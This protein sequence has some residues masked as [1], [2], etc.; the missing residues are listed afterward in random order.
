[1]AASDQIW[2]LV[3]GLPEPARS[4]R[5]LL[6]LQAYIDDSKSF[7]ERAT[8]VL[9]GYI[10]PASCWA[11]FSDAWAKELAEPPQLAYFKYW[12]AMRR[13]P[14]GQFRHWSAKAR[15]ERLARFRAVVEQFV[16][17][18]FAVAFRVA[19][20]K[21]A[22]GR[23][24][25][26]FENPYY[27]AKAQ[28][29]FYLA[30]NLEALGLERQPIDFIFDMQVMEKARVMQAWEDMLNSGVTPDPPDLLTAILR[31]PPIFRHDTDVLPLQAADMQATH[32]RMLL[33]KMES[34]DDAHNGW[35]RM[36]GAKRQIPG[37]ILTFNRAQLDVLAEEFGR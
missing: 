21:A 28:T 20:F 26:R 12:E 27:F 16:S 15:E 33:D 36:I 9:G 5:L 29:T 14:T 1:M 19:D 30:R 24:G 22:Y 32:V 10:A 3:A 4:E 6:M 35:P 11:E 13:Y 31:N 2:A 37:A 18:E 34:V 17:A 7:G 8:F 23:W 25:K